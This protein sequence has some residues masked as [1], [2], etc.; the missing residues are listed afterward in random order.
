MEILQMKY[1]FESAQT[2]NF[3]KTAE[4]FMVPAT[5]VSASVKRLEKELGCELFDRRANR[6]ILNENG[7]ALMQSLDKIFSE[8][9]LITHELSSPDTDFRKIKI[10]VRAMRNRIT[11]SIIAFHKKYP[12]IVFELTLDFDEKDF[13]KY[14]IIIDEKSSNYPEYE[15]F[16]LYSMKL[17]LVTNS[18]N[19]LCK[20]RT[21]LSELKAQSFISWGENSN[22]HRILINACSSKGFTPNVCVTTNDTKCHERLIE[23]GV[24]IG[25][26]REDG[27]QAPGG[28]ISPIDVSDFDEVYTVCSYYKRHTAYGNVRKFLD[29][30]RSEQKNE[31]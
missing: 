20:K 28:S 1:F 22:M 16:E 17:R 24:G 19:S 15:C 26:A 4:K 9:N 11:E 8:I 5:S 3:T 31:L 12:A 27:I 29:F 21:K 2:E 14:D 7:K 25:I 23:S 30:L 10:L 13:G 18:S 6:I